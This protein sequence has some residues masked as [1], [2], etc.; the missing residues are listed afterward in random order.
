[1]FP[2]RSRHARQGPIRVQVLYRKLYWAGL[3]RQGGPI[4]LLVE[5]M[6]KDLRS[7]R[8]ATSRL[9]A[10]FKQRIEDLGRIGDQMSR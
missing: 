1:M 3:V 5:K 8:F 2:L 7:N 6:E 10:I 4:A 9:R